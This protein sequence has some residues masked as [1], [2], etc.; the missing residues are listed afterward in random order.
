MRVLLVDDEQDYLRSMGRVIESLGHQVRGATSVA[1]GF[2]AVLTW[3]PDVVVL[4]VLLE[5]HSGF[6]LLHEM[7]THEI[8]V[9]VIMLTGAPDLRDAHEARRA[10]VVRYLSKP[11]DMAD[12]EEALDAA[13]LTR[14]DALP[15]AEACSPSP[16]I[17]GASGR[18]ME[19]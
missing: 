17:G 10:G 1:T 11:V 19:D 5:H 4:D 15:T 3:R 9:P 2:A 14:P 12:L 13:Q 18:V 6:D 8:D 16:A 7:A